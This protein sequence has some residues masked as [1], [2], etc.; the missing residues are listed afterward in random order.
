[1]GKRQSLM[2]N[3]QLDSIL[4][5]L[6]TDLQESEEVYRDTVA[7]IA[8]ENSILWHYIYKLSDHCRSL[9]DE[10]TLLYNSQGGTNDTN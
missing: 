5:D 10:L 2:S 1:M 4:N 9:E 3:G 7:D 8:A 6:R